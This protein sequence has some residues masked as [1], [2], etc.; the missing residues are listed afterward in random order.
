MKKRKILI[1]LLGTALIAVMLIAVTQVSYA[2]DTGIKA[3]Y[4]VSGSLDDLELSMLAPEEGL[5]FKWRPNLSEGDTVTVTENGVTTVYIHDSGTYKGFKSVYGYFDDDGNA[6]ADR[7]RCVQEG[8]D[9]DISGFYPP[10]EWVD[11][12][13]TKSGQYAYYRFLLYEKDAPEDAEPVA[14]TNSL[15]VYIRPVAVIN[16]IKYAEAKDGTAIISYCEDHEKS[17]V[18]IRKTV[19]LNNGKKYKVAHIGGIDVNGSSFEDGGSF[20]DCEKLT[21]V[22][23]PENIVSVKTKAFFNTP[24]LKKVTIPSSVK[25]IGNY[26]FGYVGESDFFSGK[27]VVEKIPDFVIYAEAGSEGAR[28]AK[29]NGFKCIDLKARKKTKAADAAYANAKYG[30]ARVKGVKVKKGTKKLTV[31]WKKV[32]KAT[33]YQIRYSTDKNFK[34]N[35]KTKRVKT[36]KKQGLTIK[37]LKKNKRY[38]VQ[39]R[40]Y[41]TVKGKKCYGKWSAKKS[42]KVR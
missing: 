11:G 3:E 20:Q 8:P 27:M 29:N 14:K 23:I 9:D 39:V 25:K 41:R 26:A 40:G 19:T 22:Y 4:T 38:Y 18:R 15:K 35:V 17:K 1:T 7:F 42:V 10:F 12:E 31:K 24:K 16:G 34:Q 36:I 33:G 37:N 5:N 13:P 6:L 21:S 32:K 30:P 28:Y 2:E